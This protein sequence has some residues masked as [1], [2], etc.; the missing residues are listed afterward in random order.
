[1]GKYAVITGASS[2]IGSEM[3]RELSKSGYEL[4]LIAR[5]EDKLI[6]LS[7]TLGKKCVII[8][9]DLSEESECFRVYEEIKNLDIEVFINNAGFGDCG[10]FLNIDIKKAITMINVNVTAVSIFTKLMLSYFCDKKTGYLLNTASSAGL[11]PAGPYMATYYATKSYVVSLTRSI[12]KELQDRAS[13][14]Y[15]GCLCPG[16]VDTEFN[17]IAGCTHALHGISSSFCARYAIKKMF[18]KTH[19]II[20]SFPLRFFCKFKRFLPERMLI[21]MTAHQQKKKL[22]K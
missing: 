10:S 19:V 17:N 14:I 12:N 21:N 9:A 3:A 22:R 11:F 5:R 6:S 13:S 1:M 4:V 15:I 2:G 8:K 20:P 7:E 18:K 16:P